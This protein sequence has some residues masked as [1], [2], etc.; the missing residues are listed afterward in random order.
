MKG[1]FSVYLHKPLQ[2][3][4]IDYHEAIVVIIFYL[5]ATL[6][7]GVF[8]LLLFVAPAVIIPIKR[9][10]SRGFL[11]HLLYLFGYAPLTGYPHPTQN[12]FYE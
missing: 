4:W 5:L 2:I 10:Q 11:G 6:F 8:W 3:L 1:R 12:R 9:R 7:G